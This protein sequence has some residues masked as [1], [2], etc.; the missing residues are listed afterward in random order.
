MA[1]SA[2]NGSPLPL[3]YRPK[4]GPPPVG[5]AVYRDGKAAVVSRGADVSGRCVKCGAAAAGPGYVRRLT[6]GGGGGGD[7]VFAVLAV[8]VFLFQLV[9]FLFW[10]LT[11]IVDRRS[12]TV[13]VGLCDQH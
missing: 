13:V 1:A 3:G 5:S 8:V 6:S 10:L 2:S 11:V 4:V 7:G 12:R 9:V